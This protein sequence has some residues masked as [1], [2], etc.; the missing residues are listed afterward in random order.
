[1]ATATAVA[2][3]VATATACSGDWVRRVVVLYGGIALR[4]VD[5]EVVGEVDG[6]GV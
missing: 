6:V 3:A 5:G 2:T 4:A 1:M